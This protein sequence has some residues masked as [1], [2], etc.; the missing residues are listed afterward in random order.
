MEP[1]KESLR[2]DLRELMKHKGAKGL[3]ELKEQGGVE[4]I[5]IKLRSS[6]RG[7]SENDLEQRRH[8]FGANV[9]PPK[10]AKSFLRLLC[11][12]L[13]DE[14]LIVLEIAALISLGLSF[15]EQHGASPDTG[16]YG[17]IEGVAILVSVMLVVFVTAFNDFSKEKQFRSLQS[18]L[19]R[20]YHAF[21]VRG[22]SPV[23]IPIAELVVGDI[24]QIKYGDLLPA[25]GILVRGND[26]K[27]C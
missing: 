3:N 13:K 4:E 21:V 11:D 16:N 7:L 27:V 8:V 24:C 9:I 19:K 15:Y 12:A 26:L 25:D 20:E 22:G 18:Q 5:L 23:Q 14:T 17:W 10:L 2:V 6:E 1:F